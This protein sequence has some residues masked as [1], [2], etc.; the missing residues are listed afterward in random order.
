M[1][2]IPCL[3]RALGIAVLTFS[4]G[5]AN[6]QDKPVRTASGYPAKAVR[7]IV[8]N[9]PGGGSDTIGRLIAQKLNE[10]LGQAF[11]IENRAGAGGLVGMEM[12]AKADPDGYTLYIASG[13]GTVNAV[14]ISKVSYDVKKAFAPVAQLSAAPSIL[15]VNPALPIRSVKELIAYAKANPGK[16]N[17][18]SSGIGSSA[19]LVGELLNYRAGIDMVHVPYKGIGPG[20]V[21]VIAGRTQVLVGSAI[22]TMPHVKSGKVRAIA[23]TSEKRARSM[24]DFPAISEAGLPGFNWVGWFGILAPAG[25]PQPVIALLNREIV[26][27]LANPDVLAALAADGSEAAPGSPEQLREAFDSGLDQATKLVKDVGLKL[28]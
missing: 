24:P 1:I 17:Y 3:A 23:V 13:S 9:A 25:T 20:I 7:I 11:I 14:L 6:G 8:G 27:A 28:E 22:S 21:D 2:R 12:A 10:R 5:F 16:L 4:M 26:A 18:A 15:A 19:H